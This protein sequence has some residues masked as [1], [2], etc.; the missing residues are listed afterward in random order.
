MAQAI[1]K[2]AAK[3]M[4]DSQMKKYKHKDPVGSYVRSLGP[5]KLQA[6]SLTP[7]RTHRTPT[8]SIAAILA[9]AA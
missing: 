8:T 6:H 7:S 9:P 4:L 2:Y 5:S 3:K 1:G